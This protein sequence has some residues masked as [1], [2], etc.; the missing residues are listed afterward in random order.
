MAVSACAKCGGHAFERGH[1]T[2]LGEQRTVQVLQCAGCG[3][4]IGILDPPS[5][6][7]SLRSQIAQ[8][9]AGLVRIARALAEQ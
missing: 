4:V 7:E 9:D 8:I 1:I 3:A 5:A 2:P 6:L